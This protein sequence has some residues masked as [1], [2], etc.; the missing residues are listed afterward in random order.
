MLTT[1][2]SIHL[3]SE[4]LKKTVFF[5]PRRCKK[6]SLKSNSEI[7]ATTFTIKKLCGTMKNKFQ[8]N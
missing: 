5:A 8:V 2:I 7:L 4:P 1:A 3:L 6:D